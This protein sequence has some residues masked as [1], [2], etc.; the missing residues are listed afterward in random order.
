MLKTIPISRALPGMWFHSL[1]GSGVHPVFVHRSFLL[2]ARE[3]DQLRRGGVDEIVIDTEQGLDLP[4]PPSPEPAPAESV[5]AVKPFD[6]SAPEPAS[7]PKLAPVPHAEPVPHVESGLQTAPAAGE[8]AAAEALSMT[9]AVGAAAEALKPSGLPVQAS[10]RR[11][12]E[13][14]VAAAR[15]LCQL[16]KQKMTE[17]FHQARLG[18]AVNPAEVEPL[19][20]EISDSVS[21]HP[22]ALISVARLK[23]HDDYTYLHSVAVCALMVALARR[24]PLPEDAVREAGIG[25]L[26]HDIGKAAMPLNILNKPGG[27]TEAEFSIMRSH[28]QAGFDMLREGGDAGA[29]ALDIALHHHEKYD[30]SGYPHGQAGEEISLFSRMGAVCDVYDAISSNRPYKN[31]WSPAESVRRMAAWQGHFDSAVFNAFVRSIGIY[32]VGALVRLQSDHLAVVL[33]QNDQT[34]L[35]PKVRVFYHARKRQPVLLR[36][37][38]LSAPRCADRIVGIEAADAWGFASLDALWMPG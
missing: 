21:R 18:R 25:G 16:G 17:L 31:A 6:D 14:E 4:L 8:P 37:L 24:L 34:L 12:M 5:A 33:E 3:I 28:P 38:D 9:A 13:A 22:D 15:L 32:P 36:E 35:A 11:S 30:G 2:S 7:V 20:Q 19:V 27:L 26:L 23:R 10:A 1:G 29:A